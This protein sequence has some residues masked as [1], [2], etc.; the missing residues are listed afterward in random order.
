MNIEG[1]NYSVVAE[2]YE[3]F[4]CVKSNSFTV[5]NIDS[6]EDVTVFLQEIYDAI[7]MLKGNRACGMDKISVEHLKLG[8]RTFCPLIAI[9]FTGLLI[10]GILPDSI[11]SV[12]LVPII[13]DKAGKMNN[14]DHYWPIALASILSKVL[15][16]IILNR[17]EQF[18]L[19]SDN[20]F[21]FKPKHGT[22]MC[23]FSFKEVLDLYNRH[24]ST[25]FICFIDASKAFDC[26]NHEKLFN[27][28]H[29]RGV[30]KYLVKILAFWYAHQSMYVRWG[31]S[32]SATF[33]VSKGV[34]QGSI[35]SPRSF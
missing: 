17:L 35:L 4:N 20:Q 18:A 13:K 7:M 12:T 15:E 8:S 24:N 27:K 11:G 2:N 23:I 33:N 30:P 1:K 9:C 21:G 3:L 26:V 16:R 31:N 14:L 25:F 6:N 10:H 34:M 19:T 29:N 32:I 28:L 5:G 22:D